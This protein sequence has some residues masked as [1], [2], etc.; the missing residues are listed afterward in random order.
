MRRFTSA[1]GREW[2]V[3]SQ[4]VPVTRVGEEVGW[5]TIL[6]DAPGLQRVGHRPAG[7]LLTADDAALGAALDESD[8]VRAR[9][10]TGLQATGG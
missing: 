2:T 7:W 5:E 3:R 10:E 8:A 6:F 1:D 4:D 9:W